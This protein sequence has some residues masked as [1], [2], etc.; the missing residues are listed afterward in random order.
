VQTRPSERY[1][2]WLVGELVLVSVLA[3]GTVLFAVTGRL[4]G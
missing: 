1:R 2:S 3:L 4:D